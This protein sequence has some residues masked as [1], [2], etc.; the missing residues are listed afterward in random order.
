MEGVG[1]APLRFEEAFGADLSGGGMGKLEKK[2][3]DEQVA[4]QPKALHKAE[5][6]WIKKWPAFKSKQLNFGCEIPDSLWKAEQPKSTLT[7][8]S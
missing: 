3:D 8:K 4:Q 1:V 5:K 2:R 6:F 7:K